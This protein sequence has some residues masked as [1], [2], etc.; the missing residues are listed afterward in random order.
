ME[1]KE[2]LHLLGLMAS[3]LELISKARLFVRPIHLYLLSFW[4]L[5]SMDL[6]V[7]I[8]VTRHLKCHLRWWL[9]PVN[10]MKG[11]SLS[12]YAHNHYHRCFQTGLWRPCRET[13][14][15][16]SVAR[17]PTK[18]TYQSSGVGSS[19]P[20]LKHFL[21]ILKNKNVLIRS[22]STTVV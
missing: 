13:F 10:T 19:I 20:N 4:S 14:H 5:A 21:L 6:E 22:D 7:T 15:S 17:I 1:T 8:P 18:A 2:F 9:N 3:C 12:T 16:G 11:R